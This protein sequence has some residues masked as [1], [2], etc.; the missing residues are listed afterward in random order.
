MA[1][2]KNDARALGVRAIV[3]KGAGVEV[4]LGE[5]HRV[6]PER[7]LAAKERFGRQLQFF[8]A[9]H[10]L[11]LGRPPGQGDTTALLR[12]FFAVLRGENAN[13]KP[14]TAGKERR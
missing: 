10:T 8:P 6:T 2:I 9:I 7:L 5:D 1:R 11:R 14:V 13:E 4:T 3:E 12:R